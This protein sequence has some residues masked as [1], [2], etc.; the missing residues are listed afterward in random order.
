MKNN[1]KNNLKNKKKIGGF[2]MKN[3]LRNKKKKGFTLIELIIVIAIIAI[4]AAIAIPRFGSVSQ[5]ARLKSDVANAKNIA[6]AASALIA[7][8]TIEVTGEV[9]AQPLDDTPASVADEVE[10]FLQDVPTPET[11]GYDVYTIAL[12]DAGNV[13]VS[14]KGTSGILELYP[15]IPTV[16]KL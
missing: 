16:D 12:D 3:N 13:T 14:M 11:A 7:D 9:S 5:D 4:I 6:N 15:A 2:F 8:G 10:K 1:L